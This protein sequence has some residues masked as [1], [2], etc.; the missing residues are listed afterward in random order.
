M[1]IAEGCVVDGLRLT[2]SGEVNEVS[3]ALEMGEVAFVLGSLKR[4]PDAGVVRLE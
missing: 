3:E 1:K 2:R 4:L